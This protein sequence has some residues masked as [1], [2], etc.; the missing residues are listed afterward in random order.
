MKATSFL[1][2]CLYILSSLIY[3][4]EL[5]IIGFILLYYIFGYG[6]LSLVQS[7]NDDKLR[8]LYSV[9]FGLYGI[10][11]VTVHFLQISN[12]KTDF[13]FHNDELYFFNQ[14][15]DM[16]LGLPW[17]KVIQG[18]FLNSYF[19]EYPGAQLLYTVIAKIGKEVGVINLRF[20]LASFITFVSSLIVAF[21]YNIASLFN[22]NIKL[23]YFLAFGCLSYLLTSCCIFTRDVL[24][25][26]I[27]T[28]IGY[29]T[30]KPDLYLRGLFFLVLVF[31]ASI[32]RWENGMFSLLF[33]AIFYAN[34]Y[35]NLNDKSVLVVSSFLVVILLF[36]FLST[37]IGEI[38]SEV[39]TWRQGTMN[40][41]SKGG[42]FQ[43]IY[44][45]PFPLSTFCIIVFQILMPIPFVSYIVDDY[46]TNVS[47]LLLPSLAT[48]FL[49]ALM[50]YCG[51]KSFL[52]HRAFL[53]LFDFVFLLCLIYVFV[54][55][56]VEPNVRRTFAA[57]PLIYCYFI[58]NRVSLQKSDYVKFWN[59]YFPVLFIINVVLS[60]VRFC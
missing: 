30:L 59:V 54:T 38:S 58:V 33:P 57:F 31:V 4:E 47:W 55:E 9:F 34:K 26:F 48:P 16:T 24:A 36:V 29:V 7:R 28:L 1:V 56:W 60:I 51:I 20:L 8:S 42:L 50:F 40:N 45:L 3:T 37:Q 18:T 5:S 44:S 11:M 39:V 41:T 52:K 19:S 14:T 23:K 15:I 49:N 27:F 12:W 21:V 10:Y 46:N 6:I 32:I 22:E 17:D 43:T 2:L 35:L 25:I 53:S 13:Y